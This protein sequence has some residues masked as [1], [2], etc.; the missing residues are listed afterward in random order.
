MLKIERMF[1]ILIR[2]LHKKIITAEE[3]A[4]EFNVS[5]RT[6]YRD[7]D[8]L[9]FAG[10]P[11]VSLPGNKGGFTLMENYQLTHFTFTE[12]E[13]M[14]LLT[15]LKMQEELLYGLHLSD[16]MQKVTL[17]TTEDAVNYVPISLSAAS[18]HPPEIDAFV[19]ANL[20][21]ILKALDSQS[22]LF[23]KY[24]S[25]AGDISERKIQ[26]QEVRFI[27]GSWYVDAHCY[28]RGAERQF[29]ITR[30]LALELSHSKKQAKEIEKKS[31]K[32]KT[33]RTK[34][35]SVLIFQGKALGR[36]VDYFVEE[37]WQELED[38]RIQ[39]DFFIE[40]PYN[41]IPFLLMFGQEVE[42]IEPQWLYDQWLNEVQAM[43]HS[44]R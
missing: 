31:T 15:G 22:N 30:M 32:P 2:L 44:K 4:L 29:K 21:I 26:P 34:E 36:L 6:I 17:L 42:I 40:P 14:S 13:K 3:L 33:I 5:K 20:E 37:E 10:I 28:L 38:G 11:V 7:M 23:I 19:K 12:A 18:Q 8:S 1:A 24:I 9:S 39:V 25:G 35:K 16:L 43:F 27:N 41:Y